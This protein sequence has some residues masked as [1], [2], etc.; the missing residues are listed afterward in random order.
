M[1]NVSGEIKETKNPFNV[2][3]ELEYIKTNKE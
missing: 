1:F 3:G 2:S